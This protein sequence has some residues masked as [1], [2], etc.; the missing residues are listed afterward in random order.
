MLEGAEVVKMGHGSRKPGIQN[1]F[2]ESGTPFET[3]R[4]NHAGAPWLIVESNSI[5]R[6]GDA[7][8]RPPGRGR[9]RSA[10]GRLVPP[11]LRDFVTRPILCPRWRPEAFCLGR[12]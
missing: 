5:L 2:Y 11:R 6:R 12:S 1:H 9:M 4:E 3:I 8:D 7:T 10:V